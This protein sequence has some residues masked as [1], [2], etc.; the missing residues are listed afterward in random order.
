MI[1]QTS[2][3]GKKCASNGHQMRDFM[4]QNGEEWNTNGPWKVTW[5]FPIGANMQ[6]ESEL[7]ILSGCN[8]STIVVK[9]TEV[10]TM[11]DICTWT[12]LIK[13][14]RMSL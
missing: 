3:K 7:N 6:S 14:N 8:C 9:K 2:K 4:S 10:N 5:Q 11:R 12:N 13:E 1:T